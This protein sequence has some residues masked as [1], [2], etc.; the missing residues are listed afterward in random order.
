MA[1]H[2]LLDLV[3]PGQHQ[4][5]GGA[6]LEELGPGR[7]LLPLHL[8]GDLGEQLEQGWNMV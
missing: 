8:D 2:L 4:L 3:A 7:L 5:G 6:L 1:G